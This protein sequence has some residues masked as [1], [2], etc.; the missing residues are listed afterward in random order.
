M[1][2]A[3]EAAGEWGCGALPLQGMNNWYAQKGF[4]INW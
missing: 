2:L 1:S 3:V 4:L